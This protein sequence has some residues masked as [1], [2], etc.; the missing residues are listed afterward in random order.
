MFFFKKSFIF[1]RPYEDHPELDES[2]HG[3]IMHHIAHSASKNEEF[4]SFM[5]VEGN[6]LVVEIENIFEEN[7]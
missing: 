5:K 3:V 4:N 1:S 6:D 2:I 7:R